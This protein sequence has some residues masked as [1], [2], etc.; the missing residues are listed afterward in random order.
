ME[1]KLTRKQFDMLTCLEQSRKGMT[2]RELGGHK[3]VPGLCK[4]NFE[5]LE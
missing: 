4:P 2:Q 1:A 5:F 3:D